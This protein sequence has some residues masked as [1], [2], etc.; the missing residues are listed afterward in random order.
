MIECYVIDILREKNIRD[1]PQLTQALDKA[2]NQNTITPDSTP[3]KKLS[4]IA[5]N[6]DFHIQ[7]VKSME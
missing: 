5:K 3:E 7:L 6:A 1:L 4:F 2:R